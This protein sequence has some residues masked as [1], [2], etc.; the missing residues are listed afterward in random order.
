[1][2][3]LNDD[4]GFANEKKTLVM[5]RSSFLSA[6][7]FMIFT[8]FHAFPWIFMDFHGFSQIFM[9]FIDFHELDFEYGRKSIENQWE[10]M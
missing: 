9:I 2:W 6:K 10:S 3:I 4:F 7:I 5:Y 1:M 8:D